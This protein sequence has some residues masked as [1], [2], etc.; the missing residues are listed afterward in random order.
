MA[1]ILHDVD[2]DKVD[3][4]IAPLG[5]WIKRAPYLVAPEREEELLQI[6][7]KHNIRLRLDATDHS[8]CV[9]AGAERDEKYIRLGLALLERVWAYCYGF[10]AIV[11]IVKKAEP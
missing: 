3:S 11:E 10:T 8:F 5:K 6:Q 2:F 1:E 7:K 9:C 4:A